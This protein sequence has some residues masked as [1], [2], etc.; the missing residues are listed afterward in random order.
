[1][2]KLKK[3][4]PVRNYYKTVGNNRFETVIVKLVQDNATH[5]LYTKIRLKLRW[6]EQ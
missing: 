3:T 4:M 1:M 2:P 5:Q 6:L